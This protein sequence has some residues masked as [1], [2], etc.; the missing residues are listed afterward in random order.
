M[1]RKYSLYTILVD[2]E[3]NQEALQGFDI[4]EEKKK[5]MNDKG[6]K[7]FRRNAIN[8]EDWPKNHEGLIYIPYIIDNNDI[9]LG[10]IHTPYIP[11]CLGIT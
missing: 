5:K 2:N 3:R 9:A 1:S 6:F 8:I 4:V 7:R 11:V 10:K